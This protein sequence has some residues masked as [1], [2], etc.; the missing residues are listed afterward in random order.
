MTADDD[1]ED[2]DP[3]GGSAL[4]RLVGA[5]EVRPSRRL[6]RLS[7]EGGWEP[8]VLGDGAAAASASMGLFAVPTS[9]PRPNQDMATI[10]D[11]GGWS[12]NCIF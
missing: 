8:A 11:C 4:L 1:D 10:V 12:I 7:E 2:D 3:V 5:L 6:E 9:A